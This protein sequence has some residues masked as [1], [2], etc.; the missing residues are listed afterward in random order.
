MS[1]YRLIMLSNAEPGKDEEFKKWYE[2]HLDDMLK[3]PGVVSA[4][5][6]DYNMELSEKPESAFKNLAVYEIS[7]DDLGQTLKA[8]QA[9]AGTDAMPMSS[10][11]SPKTSAVIYKAR[12]KRK[13]K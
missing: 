10:A 2:G 3:I 9:A 11:M 4:Q 12:S 1:D 13:S 5:V 6:F 7:T 8:L